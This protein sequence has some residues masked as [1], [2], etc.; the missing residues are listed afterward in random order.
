LLGFSFENS[1]GDIMKIKY[2]IDNNYFKCYDESQGVML[3]KGEIL[4]KP[5]IKVYNYIE[6]GIIN[7][8]FIIIM[9]ITSLFFKVFNMSMPFKIFLVLAI[10]SFILLIC[11]FMIFYIGYLVEKNKVHI[12]NLEVDA[13]GIKDLSDSG[14]IIGFSWNNIKAVV[15]KKHSICI[16]A[17]SPISLFIDIEHEERFLNA[18]NRYNP[19]LPIIDKR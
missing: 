11:Y 17:D 9:F 10:I 8:F 18:I 14:T 6:K 12:G 19:D 13:T 16:I 2:N 5:S 4:K 3:I 15:I 7:L 1:H